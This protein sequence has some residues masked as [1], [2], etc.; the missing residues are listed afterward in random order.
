MDEKT[1][2][3]RKKSIARISS[4]EQLNDYICVSSPSVWLLLA[5][6]AVLLTKRSYRPLQKIVRNLNSA[7]GQMRNEFEYIQRHMDAAA[8]KNEEMDA[9]LPQGVP[10]CPHVIHSS[11]HVRHSV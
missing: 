8:Q 9:Q 10:L 11:V 1:S 7:P 3:F 5:A 6:V 2:I 4:P